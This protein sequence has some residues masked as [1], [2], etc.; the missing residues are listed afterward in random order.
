MAGIDDLLSKYEPQVQPPAAPAPHPIEGLLD[1]YEA[2]PGPTSDVTLRGLSFEQPRP[3]LP[4][5][6]AKPPAPISPQEVGVEARAQ[7]YLSAVGGPPSISQTQMS[8]DTSTFGDQVENEGRQLFRRVGAGL[9]SMPGAIANPFIDAADNVLARSMGQPKTPGTEADLAPAAEGAFN[10]TPMGMLKGGLE[11]IA[12]ATH[13]SETTADAVDAMGNALVVPAAAAAGYAGHRLFGAARAAGGRAEGPVLEPG[14]QGR[15]EV[16]GSRGVMADRPPAPG[17]MQPDPYSGKMIDEF[18]AGRRLGEWQAQQAPPTP[19]HPPA[20]APSVDAYLRLRQWMTD[21][22]VHAPA[23]LAGEAPSASA[24]SK[25]FDWQQ[26]TGNRAARRAIGPRQESS[27]VYPETSDPYSVPAEHVDKGGYGDL[28]EEAAQHRRDA[29]Q[30]KGPPPDTTAGE[31][32]PRAG[33]PDPYA[34]DGGRIV[35]GGP[36]IGE[37]AAEDAQRA[38]DQKALAGDYAGPA[39][40]EV[41]A[42]PEPIEPVPPAPATMKPRFMRRKAGAPPTVAEPAATRS[43]IVDTPAPADRS[44][45]WR[46]P[47]PTDEPASKTIVKRVRA[48]ADA[49][50]NIAPDAM[51]DA[52][53]KSKISESQAAQYMEGVRQEVIKKTGGKDLMPRQDLAI[54]PP[55]LPEKGLGLYD[56]AVDPQALGNDIRPFAQGLQDVNVEGKNYVDS[57]VKMLSDSH[58]ELSPREH[59]AI[60]HVVN[61]DAIPEDTAIVKDRKLGDVVDR[62]KAMFTQA[63]S[64]PRVQMNG[65]QDDYITHAG[66]RRGSLDQLLLDKTSGEVERKFNPSLELQRTQHRLDRALTSKVNVYELGGW[67]AR[68]VFQDVVVNPWLKDAQRAI[69]GDGGNP[70]YPRELATPDGPKPSYAQLDKPSAA[71]L[72]HLMK[73]SFGM[74][75]DA[76]DNGL[77]NSLRWMFNDNRVAKWLGVTVDDAVRGTGAFA[78]LSSMPWAREPAMRAYVKLL[79]TKSP[80]EIPMSLGRKF[81]ATWGVGFNP[82]SIATHVL[83]DTVSMIAHNNPLEISKAFNEGVLSKDPGLLARMQRMRVLDD[84][85]EFEHNDSA[86]G[87]E[88]GAMDKVARVAQAGIRYTDQTFKAIVYSLAE[89]RLLAEGKSPEQA[90][91]GARD[92]VVSTQNYFGP[93]NTPN[94]MANK[95]VAPFTMFTRSPLRLA[96]IV[97]DAIIRGDWGTVGKFGVTVTGIYAAG[98]LFSLNLLPNMVHP[99]AARGLVA[100]A[101]AMPFDVISAAVKYATG[102]RSENDLQNMMPSALRRA[103]QYQIGDKSATDALGFQEGSSKGFSLE[104]LKEDAEALRHHKVSAGRR[105]GSGRR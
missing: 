82:K 85:P 29:A 68:Q 23:E 28:A 21:N 31:L 39:A 56:R 89:A 103:R 20:E 96:R 54:R 63:A 62:L 3:A 14:G 69:Y 93:E 64:D 11:A 100:P 97:P 84:I 92:W 9:A 99:P 36:T 45:F 80:S 65:M 24:Y 22:Q 27:A 38:A 30:Y 79:T 48:A 87:R 77:H 74:T 26:R 35:K 50:G 86:T 102:D 75:A 59:Q 40:G 98:K 72:D 25:L 34:L 90:M 52:S 104:G 33:D 81:A 91:L 19:P 88:A 5:P 53:G 44:G 4:D 46:P 105:F 94:W 7:Q 58:E 51:E 8:A 83:S 76:L 49:T 6:M 70:T 42:R 57:T 55:T 61:G 73:R 32:Y 41:R 16:Q 17:V 101:A 66:L 37:M 15:T 47:A 67:Y 43:Q 60:F 78:G 13:R 18:E 10:L 1:K 12:P 2:A 71:T 95:A